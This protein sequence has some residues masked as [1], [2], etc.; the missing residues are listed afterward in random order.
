MDTDME[1]MATTTARGLRM[2]RLPLSLKLL[3]ELRLLLK[4]LLSLSPD[5]TVMDTVTATELDTDM[6][7]MAIT[8][9][10][11]LLSLDMDIMVIHTVDMDMVMAMDTDMVAMDI[12]TAR[13]LLSP[14]TMAMDTVMVMAMDMVMDMVM[15]TTDKMV[16]NC[17]RVQC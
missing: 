16:F 3:L 10:R 7:D 15:A 14:D 8:M 11:G 12:T 1:D 17:S 2:L 4:P 5:T 9:A 6:E 13:G